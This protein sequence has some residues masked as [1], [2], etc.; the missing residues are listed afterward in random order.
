MISKILCWFFGHDEKSIYFNDEKKNKE[1]V[2]CMGIFVYLRCEH[3]CERCGKRLARD[4]S[5]HFGVDYA[6]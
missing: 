6:G 5:A 4:G 1:E 3:F 2:R